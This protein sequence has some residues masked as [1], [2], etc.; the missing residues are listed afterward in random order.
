MAGVVAGSG[1]PSAMVTKED[2]RIHLVL[3]LRW[4]PSPLPS[5]S[6]GLSDITFSRDL[7]SRRPGRSHLPLNSA[8]PRRVAH[9]L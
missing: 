2:L 6:A 5:A 9:N 4:C 1:S 8:S 7:F 3:P